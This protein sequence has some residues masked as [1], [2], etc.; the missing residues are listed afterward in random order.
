MN[1]AMVSLL[2]P[3]AALSLLAAA[4][5]LANMPVG[6]PQNGVG[7]TA[8][9]A[10]LRPLSMPMVMKAGAAGTGCS[11]SLATDRRM[12]FAAADDRAVVRLDSGIVHLRP[13]AG[14]GDLF[15]FTHDRWIGDSITVTVTPVGP[16]RW[17]GT[18]VNEGAADIEVRN[19]GRRWIARGRLSCGS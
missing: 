6:V 11:W 2:A 7:A 5:T 18:E 14:A 9:V 3:V 17:K 13:A 19:S 16:S 4:P 1:T 10:P 15:P 12:R 8:S